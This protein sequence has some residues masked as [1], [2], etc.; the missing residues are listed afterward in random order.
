LVSSLFSRRRSAEPGRA[1][2]VQCCLSAHQASQ[3]PSAA[4]LR[5]QVAGFASPH[6]SASGQRVGDLTV[7][8]AGQRPVRAEHPGGAVEHVGVG[9]QRVRVALATSRVSSGP[10]SCST[11][12]SAR[13][14]PAVIPAETAT[15]PSTTKIESSSTMICGRAS[16]APC[17]QWVGPD[18]G[19]GA[20]RT[21]RD[22]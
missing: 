17:R 12:A 15:G 8:D 16:A 22:V 5:F 20:R 9:A 14:M 7:L 13:L 2:A 18:C 21:L 6:S 10:W 19:P 11:I 3:E 4:R 1:G